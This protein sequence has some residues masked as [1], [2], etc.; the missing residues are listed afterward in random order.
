MKRLFVMFVLIC[1][2]V[3]VQA[4]Y[5]DQKE[6][7]ADGNRPLAEFVTLKKVLWNFD[8]EYSSGKELKEWRHV[9][10]PH[11]F[12][13]EQ[14]WTEDG[15]R[16]RVYVFTNASEVELFLNGKSLGVK[17]NDG[18]GSM[19]HVITWDVDYQPGT[20]L[21]VARNNE[22]KEVALHDLQT[23]GKAVKLKIEEEV[24]EWK[25]DGM[26]LHYLNVF[27]V[28]NKGRIVPDYDCKLSVN[29]SGP[30]TLLALD[31]GDHYTDDLFAG[32]AKKQMRSGK[33]QII[34]RSKREAGQVTV[35]AVSNKFKATYKTI[36][37]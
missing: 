3:M 27:A 25:S 9:D 36:T 14:P 20:I 13:F 18:K 22:G 15:S 7:K 6:A 35:S 26:D 31:N 11:D 33:M 24:S 17:L 30:A 21:A 12:Q 29:V 34:L 8:W 1:C 5:V 2:A 28:D 16:Q 4:Q 23:A 37:K 10:L 19:Q 32:I